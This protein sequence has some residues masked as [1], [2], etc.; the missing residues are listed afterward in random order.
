MKYAPAL[1]PLALVCVVALFCAAWMF[2]AANLDTLGS[3]LVSL[4]FVFVALVALSNLLARIRPDPEP[5][6]RRPVQPD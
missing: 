6:P 1:I 2:D 3:L 5:T 4:S